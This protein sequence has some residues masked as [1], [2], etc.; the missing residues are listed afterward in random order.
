MLLLILWLQG[1]NEFI[2]G[3]SLAGFTHPSNHKDLVHGVVSG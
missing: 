3:N 2:S 1:L